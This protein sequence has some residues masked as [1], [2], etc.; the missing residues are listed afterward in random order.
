MKL[1]WEELECSDNEPALIRAMVPGGWL[2][3]GKFKG[4]ICFIPDTHHEWEYK[5]WTTLP[6]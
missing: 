3:M 2:I 1:T 4:D 6:N 5:K